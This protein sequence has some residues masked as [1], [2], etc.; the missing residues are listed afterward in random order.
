M[1]RVAKQWGV[2]SPAEAQRV[3]EVHIPP[4]MWAQCKLRMRR[5]SRGPQKKKNEGKQGRVGKTMTL[6]AK[7]SVFASAKK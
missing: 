3:L 2:S 1:L 7:L 4:E 5:K 6:A